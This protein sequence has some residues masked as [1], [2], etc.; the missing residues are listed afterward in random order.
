MNTDERSRS[1]CWSR[2]VALF[3]GAVFFTGLG[4]AGYALRAGAG[5]FLH[6]VADA[7]RSDADSFELVCPA[8][9]KTNTIE[10]SEV[11]IVRCRKCGVSIDA[12]VRTEF[13]DTHRPPWFVQGFLPA[14]V[15]ALARPLEPSE[16][17]FQVWM[18]TNSRVSETNIPHDGSVFDQVWQRA[19][20][21]WGKRRGNSQ[22]RCLLLTD[23]LRSLGF[24]ARVVCGT[25]NG[26][27]Q[28]WIVFKHDGKEFLVRSSLR[29]NSR[30]YPPSVSLLAS[31]YQPDL[32]FDEKTM[33][34]PAKSEQYPDRYWSP[35]QWTETTPDRL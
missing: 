7:F 23:T 22:D 20:T 24:D 25:E 13:G 8:C 30:R 34:F 35:D 12:W 6:G 5:Y 9:G 10:P 16:A 4:F 29:E 2:L 19:A 1:G 33:Y 11:G 18:L 21:T 27:S 32:A 14:G 15:T 17:V 26:K 28:T 3:A 31:Q